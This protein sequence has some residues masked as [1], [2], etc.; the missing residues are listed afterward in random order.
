M[1]HTIA[2]CYLIFLLYATFLSRT[3]AQEYNYR[4][5]LMATARQVFSLEGRL[6]DL[7]KGDFDVIRLTGPQALEGIVV[8]VLLFVPLGY[9]LPQL[10]STSACKTIAIGAGVSVGIEIVQLVSKLGMLELDDLVFNTLGTALGLLL[11]LWVQRGAK[12]HE[13][14]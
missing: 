10:F 6:W 8:N 2:I 3:V 5:Q 14:Y 7:F 1:L 11:L 13:E 12:Q 4:L 9:L